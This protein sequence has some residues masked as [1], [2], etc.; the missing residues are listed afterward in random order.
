MLRAGVGRSCFI[1]R[2]S[3]CASFVF[4]RPLSSCDFHSRTSDPSTTEAA[5]PGG[6]GAVGGTG[7]ASISSASAAPPSSFE[8]WASSASTSLTSFSLTDG[9]FISATGP[10]TREESCHSRT[11]V[12]KQMLLLPPAVA[13]TGR[14][15]STA[16]APRTT[17]SSPPTGRGTRA[18][19]GHKA[20]SLLFP[21]GRGDRPVFASSSLSRRK[22]SDVS[23]PRQM[24]LLPPG[25]ACRPVLGRSVRTF[26]EFWCV[27][28]AKALEEGA[29]AIPR[30]I[31][32]F[33]PG[34]ASTVSRFLASV[35]ES[36]P[37]QIVDFPPGGARAAFGR[38][39]ANTALSLSESPKQ[40]V[41][42][43]PGAWRASMTG[44]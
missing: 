15:T 27:P 43:P 14:G 41:D 10:R 31:V 30:L 35:H 32:D 22:F 1:V 11:S 44:K 7:S 28:Q 39:S 38:A 6:T 16:F 24:V 4:T 13:R 8:S 36:M 18:S 17:R 21:A 42:A 12:P 25:G 5:P 29:A 26:P 3:P 34:G 33:P 37:K 19:A 23:I 9:I 2:S 40:I 20:P